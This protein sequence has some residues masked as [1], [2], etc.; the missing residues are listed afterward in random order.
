[1]LFSWYIPRAEFT[2]E[3]VLVEAGTA[4]DARVTAIKY[5]PTDK[6]YFTAIPMLHSTSAVVISADSTQSDSSYRDVDEKYIPY[7]ADPYF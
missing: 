1:M 2:D 7:V 4:D 6:E 3:I 5:F